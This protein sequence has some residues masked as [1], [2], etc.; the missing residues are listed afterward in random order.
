MAPQLPSQLVQLLAPFLCR[1]P[2]AVRSPH[3]LIRSPF[4]DGS[5]SSPLTASKACPTPSA[6]CGLH[7][8]IRFPIR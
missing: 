3:S 4:V 2:S 8:L 5:P 7:S 1:L 6:V